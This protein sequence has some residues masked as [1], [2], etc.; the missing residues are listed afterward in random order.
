MIYPAFLESPLF[1]GSLIP[2]F[3]LL[4]LLNFCT[5][6]AFSGINLITAK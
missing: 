4:Q 2:P 1:E 5:P 3:E 6:F